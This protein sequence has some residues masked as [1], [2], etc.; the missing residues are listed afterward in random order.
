MN[1]L[2]PYEI[3]HGQ[4][5]HSSKVL[6][7][8][9]ISDFWTFVRFQSQVRS[10]EVNSDTN[11]WSPGPSASPSFVSRSKFIII[12]LGMV[13]ASNSARFPPFISSNSS[14]YSSNS[15]PLFEYALSTELLYHMLYII[16]N[17]WLTWSDSILNPRFE[18]W[19]SCIDTG[20]ILPGTSNS[21]A[22]YAC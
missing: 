20:K 18:S 16:W 22:R 19:D 7:I 1:S 21:K 12:S 10:T 17:H 4:A 13:G 6:L 2:R 8:L 3:R 11:S 14:T 9:T 15:L 5:R